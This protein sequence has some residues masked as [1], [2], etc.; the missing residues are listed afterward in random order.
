MHGLPDIQPH[1]VSNVPA[2]TP[3]VGLAEALGSLDTFRSNR[4]AITRGPQESHLMFAAKALA[5]WLLLWHLREEACLNS[6]RFDP[7]GC[8]NLSTGVGLHYVI[9]GEGARTIVLVHGHP[10]I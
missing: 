2:R 8:A 5:Y 10:Q 7:H 1:V 4:V 6:C 9:D 3:R